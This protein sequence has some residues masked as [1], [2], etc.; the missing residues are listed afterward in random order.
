MFHKLRLSIYSFFRYSIFRRLNSIA[1]KAT[2]FFKP[3]QKLDHNKRKNII[4]VSLTSYG[5]RTDSVHIT[6]KSLFLQTDKPD[7]IILNLAEDEFSRET[8]PKN[9]KKL[10][11]FGLVINFTKDIGSYK[12]LI[13]T[14][15]LYPDAIIITV[16]DDVYYPSF[17]VKKLIQAYQAEPKKIHGYRGYR[18]PDLRST[19][20]PY[21]EWDKC[22]SR[23]CGNDIML[24]GVGAILYW[25]G[26]FHADIQKE[27]LF[28]ELAPTA[29]DLWFKAMTA[30]NNIPSNCLNDKK[31]FR[32]NF[33]YTENSL[34][35]PLKKQNVS[36]RNND[37]TLSKLIN[38]YPEL[39]IRLGNYS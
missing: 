17:M 18:I 35:T 36:L 21:S 22:D 13:P 2:L 27:E 32:D 25:P 14:L 16:D 29:D 24:T 34:V 5:K 8:I 3:I 12:K 6:I 19:L 7:V 30:L 31:F 38:K 26:C 9:L 15:R 39:L 23:K 20:V 1:L 10:E 33:R 28:M 11:E 4:V 37:I